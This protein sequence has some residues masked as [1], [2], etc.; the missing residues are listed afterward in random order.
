VPHKNE[1]YH[2]IWT[3]HFALNAAL[4]SSTYQE[5]ITII[6]YSK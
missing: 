3:Q 2:I 6:K 1:G 4:H 5:I